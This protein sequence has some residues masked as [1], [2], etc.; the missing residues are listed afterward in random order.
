[1]P[2]I[3][4]GH[5]ELSLHRQCSQMSENGQIEFSQKII[6][7]FQ[8]FWGGGDFKVT[9]LVTFVAWAKKNFCDERKFL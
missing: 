3:L 2:G 5:L 8:K 1:M 7:G 4:S 9:L 6:I